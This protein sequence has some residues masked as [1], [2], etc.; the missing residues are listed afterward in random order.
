MLNEEEQITQLKQQL[1]KMEAEEKWD[2]VV[3]YYRD[4]YDLTGDESYYHK[5]VEAHIKDDQPEFAL[6]LIQDSK[7]DYTKDEKLAPIYLEA[8]LKLEDFEG[9]NDLL[10]TKLKDLPNYDELYAHYDKELDNFVSNTL[11]ERQEIIQS[12]YQLSSYT[13]E[14]QIAYASK[15]GCL[16]NE[17]LIEVGEI[18]LP[19][20]YVNLVAK[21]AFISVMSMREINHKFKYFAFDEIFTINPADLRPFDDEPEINRLRNMMAFDLEDDPVMHDIQQKEFAYDLMILYPIHNEVIK[22]QDD[23]IYYYDDLFS[24]APGEYYT[25]KNNKQCKYFKKIQKYK[26]E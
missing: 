7:E 19:N 9:A 4:L 6:E 10:Q 3:F 23:W 5:R 16:Q 1:L 21:T 11:N 20:P 18:M 8:Y 22:D 26:E 14:E 25:F 2:T 24:G 13:K 15:A 12:L 17:R